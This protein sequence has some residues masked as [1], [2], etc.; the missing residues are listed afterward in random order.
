MGKVAEGVVK[1]MVLVLVTVWVTG[2]KRA[3]RT[4]NYEKINSGDYRG[5][6]ERNGFAHNCVSSQ[7]SYLWL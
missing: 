5:T 6:N 4:R 3:M 1:A 7:S 2:R